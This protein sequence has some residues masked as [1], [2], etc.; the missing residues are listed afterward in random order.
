MFTP[1]QLLTYQHQ[2]SPFIDFKVQPLLPHAHSQNGPGLTVGDIN[3]DGR[4]DIYVGGTY[5]KRGALFTQNR[6]GVFV[7]DSLPNDKFSYGQDM[8]ALLFDADNDHDLDLYI[9]SGGSEFSPNSKHYRHRFYRNNGKGKLLADTSAL[10]PFATSGAAVTAADYDR[11]GDLDIF[12][13]GRLVPHQYP[14]VPQSF[15][16]R[17][18]G[19]KFTDVTDQLAPGLSRIGL[20]SAAIWTDVDNDLDLDLLLAGE[21]MPLTLFE[22]NEGK[23]VNA[24]ANVGLSNTQGWWNSLIAADFD[25]DGDMDYLAGNAGL[26]TQYRASMA[27]PISLYAKDYDENGS[28][29]PVMARYVMGQNCPV[30]TRDMLIDQL[31]GMRKRFPTYQDYAMATLTDVFSAEE[32]AGALLCKSVTLQSSYIENKGN[33]PNGPRFEITPLPLPVQMAP[34]HGMVC[35]DYDQDGQLDVL[36]VG[37]SYANETVSGWNNASNGLFLRGNGKGGFSVVR[38]SGFWVPGD[39]KALAELALTS[40]GSLLV[41]TQ[42]NDFALVFGHRPLAT[43]QVVTLHSTDAYAVIR[44]MDGTREKREF[45]YGDGYLSQSSRVLRLGKTVQSAEIYQYTGQSRK[46]TIQYPRK[47]KR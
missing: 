3:G 45:S 34:V 18:D 35:Q 7:A 1:V 17:N 30:P 12:V 8:G 42:N 44:Y 46:V 28:L 36:I 29:D 11:D 27:Q 32:L 2:S 6:H 33:S 19:G 41:A 15:L 23:F 47:N 4:E 21:W 43:G 24:T 9:A 22:N 5:Q 16:L 10:P 20:V 14:L 40:G 13:A 39:G 25:H 38:G 31:V 26:N 37:N